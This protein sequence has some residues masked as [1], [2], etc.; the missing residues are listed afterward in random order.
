MSEYKG[1]TTC[2][3]ATRKHGGLKCLEG[4]QACYM[5]HVMPCW[6]PKEKKTT[7]TKGKDK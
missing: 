6:K 5:G 4:R 7:T 2:A 1:F 3:N